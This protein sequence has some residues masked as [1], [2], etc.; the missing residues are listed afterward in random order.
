MTPPVAPTAPR[1]RPPITLH[2]GAGHTVELAEAHVLDA[3]FATVSYRLEPEGWAT[4]FPLAL[5]ALN[6]G[7]LTPAQA[8]AALAELDLIAAELRAL[9]A[10]RAVWDYQDTRPWDDRALPVRHDAG[11]LHDYFVAADG[12][13]P[14]V[15]RLREAAAAAHERGVALVVPTKAANDARQFGLVLLV[16]GLALGVA[17]RT[18]FPRWFLTSHGGK[19][20]V[21]FWA[22]GFLMAGFG[23]WAWW[24]AR[25][26]ALAG[27]RRAHPL[28]TG[29][30]VAAA[31]GV[32]LWA[33]WEGH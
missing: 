19:D 27:W 15:A 5:D 12:R 8:P 3:F 10:R 7:R 22:L 23:G 9:P 33:G 4:R 17:A 6:A 16:S 13:T 20:G 2:L 28:V 21:A 1:R 11:S 30:L 32:T 18:W 29:L 14:L 24:E 25:F 31:T 26:P